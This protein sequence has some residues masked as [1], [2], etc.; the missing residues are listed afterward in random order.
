M[1]EV[2]REI[3]RH[4]G[5]VGGMT[6]LSRILG[7]VRDV[8]LA[9]VFGARM[10]ADVFFV[11]FRI[12]NLFRRLLAEGALTVS[13]V[14]VFSEYLHKDKAEARRIVAIAIT[15]FTV[16]LLIVSAVAILCAPW[17]VQAIVYGF[18]SS[19]EKFDLTVLMTRLMFPYLIFVSLA[20]LAMGVLNSLKHFA[21]PASSPIFLNIGIIIGAIGFS[22]YCNP[23]VIGLAWGVLLGGALQLSINIPVLIKYGFLPMPQWDLKH[24][25]VKKITKLMLPSAYG[26][27]VYQFNVIVITL[28]ASFLPSGSVSYLWYADRIMEFPLGIFGIALASVI[29][30][31]LSAHA[32]RKE[33]QVFNETLVYGLRLTFFVAIPAAVGL[34]VLAYPIVHIIFEHGSFTAAATDATTQALI[35]FALGLPFISGVRMLTNAF[36]SLQDAK[37]P[38]RVANLSVV[39]NLVLCV[40]LMQSLQHAGL[41]LAISLSAFFNFVVQFILFKRKVKNL[42]WQPLLISVTKTC[43]ASFVMAGTVLWA[44]NEWYNFRGGPHLMESIVWLIF[45]IILGVVVFGVMVWILKSVEVKEVFSL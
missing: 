8:V 14:P 12:P 32:A 2:K 27:A 37:T 25:A 36:Y 41:A 10:A 1:S 24:P 16:I 30:P 15:V 34:I 20:A 44:M 39:V 40:A 11:A 33:W 43:V 7:L 21:A 18:K 17:I 29:L 38:V 3:I 5:T 26:A 19:P 35:Y 4:A 45:Y 13:F 23:P 42:H 31:A 9:H 28:L 22:Q 6:F